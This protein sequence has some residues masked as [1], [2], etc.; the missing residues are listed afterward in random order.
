[1]SLDNGD[2]KGSFDL[3]ICEIKNKIGNES[4]QVKIGVTTIKYKMREFCLRWID[5]VELKDL[6]ML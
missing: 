6:R 5:H 3:C 2:E 4:I 1:M